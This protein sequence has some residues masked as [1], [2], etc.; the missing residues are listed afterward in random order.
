MYIV[1]VHGFKRF[2]AIGGILGQK[3]KDEYFIRVCV[4]GINFRKIITV[5]IEYTDRFFIDFFPGLSTIFTFIH[6]TSGDAGILET[7]ITIQVIP[8]RR[9]FDFV[10]GHHFLNSFCVVFTGK[11]IGS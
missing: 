8:E 5:G 9:R 10:F 7:V 3:T 6:F 11:T 1:L 2:S 4:R